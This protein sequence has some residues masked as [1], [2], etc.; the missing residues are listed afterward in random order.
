LTLTKYS[1]FD[2]EISSTSPNDNNNYIF[3]RGIDMYQRPNPRIMR[4]G[5][6][7]TF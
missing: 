6:Q 5:V 7:L 2:P 1:G 4:L 3:Q